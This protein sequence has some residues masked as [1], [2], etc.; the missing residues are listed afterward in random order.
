MTGVPP[1]SLVLGA[2]QLGLSYGVAN[3]TGQPDRATALDIVRVAWESGIAEFDTAQDYGDSERVLGE[4]FQNLGISAHARVVSKIDPTFD[5]LDRAVMTA[6]VDASLTKLGVPRLAGLL[7]H[8]EAL[9][10]QWDS[11]VHE[12]LSDLVRV[13]KVERLGVSVYS[14]ERAWEAL[15]K[16]GID[17]VQLPSNILDRRFEALGVFDLAEDRNKRIYVRSAYLQ[18]LILMEPDELPS[19][20]AFSRPVVERVKALAQELHISV[21][22][23]ALGYLRSRLP[24]VKLVVGAETPEQVLLNAKYGQTL[25]TQDLVAKVA[26]CFSDV[27]VKVLNPA[28]WKANT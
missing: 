10:D 3:T 17:M 28:L 27:D 22:A 20:V 21:P 13:G 19:H 23:L 1:S 7:L 6:A 5:H 11:G 16:D 2:V 14:P 4:A 26:E 12:V 8:H 25:L 15:N 18:G 24:K 9:L